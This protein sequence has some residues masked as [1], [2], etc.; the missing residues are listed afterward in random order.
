MKPIVKRV[1]QS[2]WQGFEALVAQACGPRGTVVV[3]IDKDK[4]AA[5]LYTFSHATG[6]TTPIRLRGKVPG[7]FPRSALYFRWSTGPEPPL[8]G[9]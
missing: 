1:R 2:T 3:G 5:Y 4:Q 7:T 6:L 8:F 9:E